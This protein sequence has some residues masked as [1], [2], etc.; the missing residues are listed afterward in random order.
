MD[1]G[2]ILALLPPELR[3]LWPM[4]AR[5]RDVRKKMLVENQNARTK[6]RQT[7]DR[8]RAQALDFNNSGRA[9]TTDHLLPVVGSTRGRKGHARGDRFGL[10]HLATPGRGSGKYKSSTPEYICKTGFAPPDCAIRNVSRDSGGG[11]SHARHC[12][13]FVADTV[14]AAQSKATK[15]RSADSRHME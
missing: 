1:A 9:R 5:R 7:L 10:T 2:A 11:H 12:G 3:G 15:K 14:M 6:R 4:R 13:F 8:L